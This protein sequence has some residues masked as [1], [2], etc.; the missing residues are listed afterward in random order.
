[1]ENQYCE[2]YETKDRFLSALL[3][4]LGLRL[5]QSYQEGGVTYF[6]FENKEECED[7]IKKYY[8]N[9]LMINPKTFVDAMQNIKHM[10][11]G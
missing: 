7:V 10:I 3:L 4:S 5:D 1:M 6:V 8:N 9:E 2:L 11:H